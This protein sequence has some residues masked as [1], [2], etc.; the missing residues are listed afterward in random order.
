MKRTF[1]VMAM[2]AVAAVFSLNADSANA[3]PVK[4]LQQ[5]NSAQTESGNPKTRMY[6]APGGGNPGYGQQPRLGFHGHMIHGY[7]MRVDHVLVGTPAQQVG[8]EGG[9]VIWRI[10]GR[11]ILS[12]F[13]YDNAMRNA[14]LYQGGWLTLTVRNVRYDMGQSYQQFVT[15]SVRAMG[16]YAVPVAGTVAGQPGAGQP[17]GYLPYSGG[18][19]E[20]ALKSGASAG[21]VGSDTAKGDF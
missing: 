8:L 18:Y 20:P 13:D 17:S 11:R 14:A 12:R 1:S 21:E 19:S 5:D 2:I 16:G 6:I 7:G 15:V 10:D 3:Q 4:L 9:D